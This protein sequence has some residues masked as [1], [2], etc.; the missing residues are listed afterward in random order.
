MYCGSIPEFVEVDDV[1]F[2]RPV[3]VGSLLQ[4][5]SCVLFVD[6]DNSVHVEV[7]ASVTQPSLRTSQLS[8]TFYFTFR[9]PPDTALLPVV[10]SSRDVATRLVAR[11][12][13]DAAQSLLD[14]AST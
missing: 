10:P 2:R 9:A 3:E 12:H 1:T 5:E 14:A 13:S 7:M 8:N 6:S 4:L 11:R